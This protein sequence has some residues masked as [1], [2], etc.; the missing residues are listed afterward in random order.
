[1]RLERP[2]AAWRSL[3]QP[4]SRIKVLHLDVHEE[5]RPQDPVAVLRYVTQA[6]GRRHEEI[7]QEMGG[8]P[9]MLRQVLDFSKAPPSEIR[10]SLSSLLKGLQE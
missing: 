2:E 5:T 8:L 7:A 9:W 4:I 1:M 10:R 6:A 3:R